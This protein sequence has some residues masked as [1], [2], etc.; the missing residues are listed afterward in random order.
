LWRDCGSSMTHS[1]I[2]IFT[3]WIIQKRSNERQG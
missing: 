3:A 2:A 1:L